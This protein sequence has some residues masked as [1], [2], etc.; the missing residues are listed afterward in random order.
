VV[1]FY[2]IDTSHCRHDDSDKQL[3]YTTI[4]S[5]NNDN[6]TCGLICS[7]GAGPFS[8]L[9]GGSANNIY[10]IPAPDQLSFG[11]STLLAAA[12]CI[13]AILSL[14]HMWIKI[15][16]TRSKKSSDNEG[17]DKC[18]H[19]LCRR[20]KAIDP[21]DNDN[22]GKMSWLIKIIRSCL[23]HVQMI[24]LSGAVLT[25]LCIGEKNFFSPQVT[26]QTEPIGSIGK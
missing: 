2:R 9:R 10:V 12:C 6:F 18:H 3:S 15:Y 13:P 5:L 4:D 8:P 16:K 22:V 14:L 20:Y 23:S 1:E 11:T 21:T 26:Y 25:I 24:V 19:C 17:N 7:T